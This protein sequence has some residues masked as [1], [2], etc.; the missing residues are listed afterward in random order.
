MRGASPSCARGADQESV[1]V[2]GFSQVPLQSLPSVIRD[3]GIPRPLAL[4]HPPSPAQ[5]AFGISS[6]NTVSWCQRWQT[7]NAY[8][9]PPTEILF[10]STLLCHQA[11][12]S[13]LN[14]P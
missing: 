11:L 9:L 6:G 4:I 3:M 1:P 7:T 12:V 8:M 10:K 2:S 14:A 5:L 13:L